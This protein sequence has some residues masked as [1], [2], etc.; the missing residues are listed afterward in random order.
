MA[1]DSI[2]QNILI[3]LQGIQTALG[4]RNNT[5]LLLFRGPG[6]I[7]MKYAKAIRKLI[8]RVDFEKNWTKEQKIY[9]FTKK[10]RTNLSYALWPLLVLKDNF[11]IDMAI[12]LAQ[13]I[14]NNQRMHLRSILPVFASVFIMAPAL[15]MAAT[16]FAIQIQDPNKQLIDRLTTN[17]A[18]L[19]E[20]LAQ[21]VRKNQ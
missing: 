16:S 4:Q 5:S 21:A 9:S 10:L 8:K 19:L 7:V 17:L 3:A 11:T 20:S 1:N 14:E 18:W 6:E 13:K 15:Q 12:K 2:Q